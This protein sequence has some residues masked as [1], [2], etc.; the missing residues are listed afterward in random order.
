MNVVQD[1]FVYTLLK[2]CIHV[3]PRPPLNEWKDLK[4][5]LIDSAMRQERHCVTKVRAGTT[6][7]T[8]ELSHLGPACL[9]YID[10][11]HRI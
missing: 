11:L 3:L 10:A 9:A 8:H 7:D 1:K 4:C 6:G 2:E 5:I